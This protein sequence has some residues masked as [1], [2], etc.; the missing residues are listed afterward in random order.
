M[1]E[2]RELNEFLSQLLIRS[3]SAIF[4]LRRQGDRFSLA[5]IAQSARRVLVIPPSGLAEVMLTYPAISILRKALPES[6]IA[7]LIE[8]EQMDVLRGFADIDEYI[9]LP[10]LSGMK[11]MGNYRALIADVKEKMIEAVFF[12]D[13]RWDFYRMVLPI[14]CDAKVRIH[15]RNTVGY[16]LFNVEVVPKSEASYLSDRNLC[17]VSFL[18]GEDKKPEQWRLPENEQRIAREI[19]GLRRTI[20]SEMLVA[21]DLSYTKSGEK[22]PYEIALKL[23]KSYSALVSSKIVLLSD[24]K[25]CITPEETQRIGSFEWF[26]VRGKNFRDT[27]GMLSQCDLLISANTNLFHFGVAMGIP[28]FGLF[29]SKD[30]SIWIPKK[31][32]FEIVDQEVWMNTPPAQ[33]AMRM[34][35]FVKDVVEK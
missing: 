27:L 29:S 9:E 18:A 14:L 10:D 15:L 4:R 1:R 12:F 25:P 22:S 23:A 8:R 21:V 28:T 24:P 26:Q 16:P 6:K 20:P 5:R 2:G 11:A 19:A 30:G 35:D 17:L 32:R 31:G 7:C 34:R 33:L 3:A 13:F